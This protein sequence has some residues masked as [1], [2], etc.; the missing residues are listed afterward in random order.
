MY[1]FLYVSVSGSI[2][3]NFISLCRVLGR[4]FVALWIKKVF[5]RTSPCKARYAV[6][7]N[8]CMQHWSNAS[9]L[10]DSDPTTLP[11]PLMLVRHGM[12]LHN[13]ECTSTISLHMDVSFHLE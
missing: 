2:S 7:K 8:E 1:S 10:H 3:N 13:G 4:K 6:L 9:D 11:A 12:C 5:G